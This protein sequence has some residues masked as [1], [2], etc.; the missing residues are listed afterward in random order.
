[1]REELGFWFTV[2]IAAVVGIAFFKIIAAK[3]GNT[4]PGLAQLAQ[5]V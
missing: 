2:M 3:L 5:F 1:M 4:I